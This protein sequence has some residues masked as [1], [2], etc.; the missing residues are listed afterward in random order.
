MGLL[1]LLLVGCL[2][3]EAADEVPTGIDALLPPREQFALAPVATDAGPGDAPRQLACGPT[4]GRVLRFKVRTLPTGGRFAPKN[5]GAIW[6]TDK[7]GSFVKTLKV[8]GELRAKWLEA[9]QG[10]SGGDRTDAITG[11]TLSGHET[12]EIL[13]PMTDHAGCEILPG[14]YNIR[15]ELTDRSGKGANL[16]LPFEKADAPLSML[17]ADAEFFRDMAL[18]LE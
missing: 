16:S 14:L 15:V 13:W 9:W 5:V 8:W 7:D 10:S 11:A 18:S 12:H 17:P 1:A 6:I 3:P 4:S 2:Q